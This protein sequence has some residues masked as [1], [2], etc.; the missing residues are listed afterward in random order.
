MKKSLFIIAA[1][2]LVV[3]CSSD[4]I[5]NNVIEDTTV[6]IGFGDSYIGKK[7]KAVFGEINDS[8]S[9][10]KNGSTLKVWGWKNVKGTKTPVFT[11]QRVAFNSSS[12]QS[13]TKWVYTPLKFWDM[14]AKEYLFIAAAPDTALFT[15][16]NDTLI[17][18]SSITNKVLP[19]FDN[20]GSSKVTSSN[21]KAVDFL[22]AEKVRKAPKGNAPDDDVQFT[23]SHILS[24]LTLR[25]KTTNN[26]NNSGASYP[27]IKLTDFTVHLRGMCPSFAQKTVGALTPAATNGDTW[28]GDAMDSTA[29]V[30]YAVAGTVDSLL[31]NTTAQEIASYLVTPTATGAT[32]PTYNYYATVGYEILFSATEKE[33]FVVESKLIPTLNSFVQ[34]TSNTLTVTIDPQAIYFDV[35]TVN[36]WTDTA[37]NELEIK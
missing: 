23:F 34:N 5:R 13:T 17:S 22:V 9:L 4:S 30:C 32:P 37:D 33:H 29:Y 35:K 6:P 16:G 18:C 25:V 12:N 27:Q 1:A 11:D 19:L 7:T 21:T 14:S 20:N 31:L 3:S 28:S 2:A 24:K 15:V 10:A 26:F 8:A 36:N